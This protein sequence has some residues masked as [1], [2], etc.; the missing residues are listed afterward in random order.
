M[1]NVRSSSN[2]GGVTCLYA[3]L[4]SMPHNWTA[5]LSH[6]LIHISFFRLIFFSPLAPFVTA[7]L[8]FRCCVAVAMLLPSLYSGSRGTCTPQQCGTV[9]P[10]FRR[11]RWRSSSPLSC[12]RCSVWSFC[13][14]DER[15]K[16][17]YDRVR[18]RDAYGFA[19][20]RHRCL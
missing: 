13:F 20:K 5:S 8:M 1:H 10:A 11:R 17:R 7:P 16:Q 12:M 3:S 15:S 6:S 9:F 18:E 14:G 2:R 4:P 19:W